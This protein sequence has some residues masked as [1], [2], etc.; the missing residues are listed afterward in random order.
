MK[1]STILS[2]FTM[3]TTLFLAGCD[4]SLGRGGYGHSYD[5]YYNEGGARTYDP[6]YS[7]GNYYGGGYDARTY[8]PY[9]NG[10]YYD[11]RSHREVHRDLERAH[12]A[13]HEQLEHKYDKAM[14]RLN[15]QERE[16]EEKAL[17]KSGGN[18]NDPRFQDTHRKIDQKYDAKREQVEHNLHKDHREFH[19]DLNHEHED[20]HSG[21]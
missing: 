20:S 16:A 4:P 1:I 10:G 9:G 18:P 12:E 5:P 19:K 17:R 7:G 11:D 8:S 15:R 13:E 21:W 6:Y 3:G 14:N 2:L